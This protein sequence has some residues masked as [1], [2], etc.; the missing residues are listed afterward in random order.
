MDI[1]VFGYYS[2]RYRCDMSYMFPAVDSVS[3]PTHTPAQITDSNTPTVCNVAFF[4][5][6]KTVRSFGTEDRPTERP[7]P[8]RDEVFEY[9]IFRGSDI[10]D[11]TVCEPPKATSTLPQDPA[12]VQSS[13]GSTSAAS[14][15]LFQS[16]GSY[17]SFSRASVPSY[18]QFGVTPIGSQQFASTGGK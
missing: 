4:F 8:P 13:I 7:I 14:A 11:L 12:I 1:Y 10:K 2:S 3:L 18:N 15:P 6:S 17:A 9:I 5:F 16:A